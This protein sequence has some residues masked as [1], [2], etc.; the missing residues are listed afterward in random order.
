[1]SV[2]GWEKVL[3]S[4]LEQKFEHKCE[5]GGEKFEEKF[6]DD[7]GTRNHHPD[8]EAVM[9]TQKETIICAMI[10]PRCAS[11]WEV[12]GV[13]WRERERERTRDNGGGGEWMD[14][15]QSMRVGLWS[16]WYHFGPGKNSTRGN[17]S[18]WWRF[19]PLLVST[20]VGNMGLVWKLFWELRCKYVVNIWLTLRFP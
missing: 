17:K 5:E 14:V 11:T 10:A 7:F 1:M 8:S 15:F 19:F 13:G 6:G 4:P 12:Q 16:V 3:F 2:W 20:E 18:C 9:V